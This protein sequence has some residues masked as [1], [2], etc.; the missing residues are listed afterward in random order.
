MMEPVLEIYTNYV[1]RTLM[2]ETPRTLGVWRVIS[3][4]TGDFKHIRPYDTE[5]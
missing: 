2:P 5:N 3:H 1:S 4:K